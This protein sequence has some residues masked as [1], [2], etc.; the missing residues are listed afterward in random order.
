MYFSQFEVHDASY[1]FPNNNKIGKKI[2]MCASYEG[3]LSQNKVNELFITISIQRELP[4]SGFFFPGE[5]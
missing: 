3:N 5:L 4:N 2:L 1:I